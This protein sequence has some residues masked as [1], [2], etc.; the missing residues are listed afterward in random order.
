MLPW[1]DAAQGTCCTSALFSCTAFPD[2]AFG[3][4]GPSQLKGLSPHAV[5]FPG[6]RQSPSLKDVTD[7]QGRYT[8]LISLGLVFF[9]FLIS[10]HFSIGSLNLSSL[11]FKYL[12][13]Y[14]T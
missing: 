6:H 2:V 3:A 4:R 10:L 7:F 14:M 12:S 9:F 8:S 13:L 1:P 5:A 11:V